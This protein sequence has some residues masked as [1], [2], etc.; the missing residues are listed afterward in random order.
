MKIWHKHITIPFSNRKERITYTC[1]NTDE[2]KQ[3]VQL[4]KSDKTDHIL[5]GYI[6]MKCPE[7]ANLKR[8]K[9]SRLMV[10]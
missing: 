10:A 1:Y 6:Y 9:V 5:S 7:R 3:H 8:E 2:L 4:K